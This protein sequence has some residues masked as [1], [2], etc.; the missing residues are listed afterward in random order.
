MWFCLCVQILGHAPGRRGSRRRGLRK[1]E[2]EAEK[3]RPKMAL[4]ETL[5][6]SGAA[7]IA[8]AHSSRPSLAPASPAFL[9]ECRLPPS[10]HRGLSCCLHS[11]GRSRTTKSESP[12]GSLTNSARRPAPA[13]SDTCAPQTALAQADG[14]TNSR[15]V[16]EP[17]PCP[18]PPSPLSSSLL[19]QWKAEQS[20]RT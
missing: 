3:G 15:I 20:T 1:G 5:V 19:S 4:K 13:P 2:G 16:L 11:V 14:G 8:L 6:K 7:A 12:K 10:Q 9:L 18:P 17:L